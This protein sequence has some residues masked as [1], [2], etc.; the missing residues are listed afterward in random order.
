METTIELHR[1]GWKTVYHAETLAY[2]LAPH[3]ASAYHVQRLRWG[4]GAMQ[5]LRKLRPLTMKGLTLGQR[6]NYF[7][8][9]STYFEGWQKAVF[10]LMPLFFFFTGVLPIDVN[11]TEFL[12]R[13]IPYLVLAILTFELMS[14]GTG[15][16]LLSERFT[17]VRF[18]TYMLTISALFTRKPLKFNVTP[19]GRTGV[20]FRTFAPQL[21]LLVLSIAAPIWATLAFHYGWIDYRSSGWGS[22]AFWANGIWVLWNCY[23]AAYVVRHSLVMRQHRDDHRFAEQLPIQVRAAAAS[24]PAFLPALTTDLNPAGVGFRSTHRL[25]P[26]TS[27]EFDLP[28]ATGAVPVTGEVRHVTEQATKLGDIHTHGVAF[29]DLPAP[30]K[31]AIE[32]HCTQHAMPAWRLR[33]RQS[34]DIMTRTAEIFHNMRGDRRRMVGLPA[35]VGAARPD[36]D[37]LV[38]VDELVILEEISANGALLLGNFAFD[39]GTLL[40]FEVPGTEIAGEGYVRHVRALET[41]VATQFSMGLEL[42]STPAQRQLPGPARLRLAAPAADP[43]GSGNTA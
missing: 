18:F 16:L 21:T 23:F 19:K 26:G 5:V 38:A 7:A 30:T 42:T 17:M 24:G 15:Y 1:R 20:P 2:G 31:D 4:Q 14:R 29:S 43:A 25:E 32:L 11:Q 13:L 6:I 10:Y 27:V 35:R 34:I 8:G 3:S 28:L 22:V 36:D 41:S 37:E 9:T 40:R 12:V 33:Y 39:P